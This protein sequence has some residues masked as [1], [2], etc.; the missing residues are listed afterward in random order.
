VKNIVIGEEIDNSLNEMN[1]F[2]KIT[3]LVDLVNLEAEK[4]LDRLPTEQRAK[5][6]QEVALLNKAFENKGEPK[7]TWYKLSQEGILEAAKYV[8]DVRVNM[9]GILKEIGKF[10][11]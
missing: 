3:K 6:E 8:G 1:D 9:V 4:I 2:G 10:I 11:D 5:F 7:Q